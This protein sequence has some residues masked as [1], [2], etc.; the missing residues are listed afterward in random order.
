M[1]PRSLLA[2]KRGSLTPTP[3]PTLDMV[4][5]PEALA[6]QR[7]EWAAKSFGSVAPMKCHGGLVLLFTRTWDL[8]EANLMCTCTLAFLRSFTTCNTLPF[9]PSPH[10]TNPFE[11]KS[12]PSHPTSRS[13]TK[14]RVHGF[15]RGCRRCTGDLVQ[16]KAA[17]RRNP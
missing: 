17:S 8:D 16:A 14:H 12:P 4:D 15:W 3:T 1:I 10:T 13:S 6:D 5:D 9:H 2:A 11:P 7:M